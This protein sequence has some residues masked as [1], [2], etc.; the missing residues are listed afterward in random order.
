MAFGESTADWGMD[1]G[2]APNHR[3][4]IVGVNDSKYPVDNA[5]FAI[6]FGI[7][8]KATPQDPKQ[9]AAWLSK[10]KIFT[11]TK[12]EAV[13]RGHYFESKDEFRYLLDGNVW[14]GGSLYK[15]K[16]YN[17]IP[18]VRDQSVAAAKKVCASVKR[19]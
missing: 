6:D 19:G 3:V 11:P 12:I 14:C 2:D 9:Y 16:D 1:D 5:L 4:M 13:P 8:D 10:S 17:K 18:K 7:E 15:D